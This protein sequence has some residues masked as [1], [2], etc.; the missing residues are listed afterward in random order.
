M[1]SF[2]FSAAIPILPSCPEVKGERGVTLDQ[3]LLESYEVNSTNKHYHVI[4]PE[5]NYYND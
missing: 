3:T 4:S 5:I 1:L 2:S